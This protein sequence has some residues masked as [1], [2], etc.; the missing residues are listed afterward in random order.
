MAD[1]RWL[2][3]GLGN[4]GG[5]YEKTFHNVGFMAIEYL[6]QKW[7]IPLGRSKFKGRYGQG[8]YAGQ[9]VL[10]LQPETFMNLSGESVQAAADYYKIPP[11][12]IIVIYDDL[13]LSMGEVRIR[14]KGSAG[15]HNGMK[16]L[17]YHLGTED[18]LRIRI[19]IG[20]KPARWDTIDYVLA[21]VPEQHQEAIFNGLK[22][23]A[24]SIQ[25]ILE[26]DAD[27][28]MNE[29]HRAQKK[30]KREERKA[31]QELL[32]KEREDSTSE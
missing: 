18:F 16:S 11:Q 12:R 32:R 2:I 6:V 13:D 7:G 17:I 15:T 10:L 22:A 29:I 30:K 27:Y 14:K 20:P 31:K 5:K 24:D 28:A 4:P 9:S 19:G 21:E 25:L 26:E 8:R 3:A 1:E 23:A